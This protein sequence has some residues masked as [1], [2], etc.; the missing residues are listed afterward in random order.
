MAES[1]PTVTATP[2]PITPPVA[3]PPFVYNTVE[4]TRK[5]AEVEAFY[6][7]YHGRAGFNPHF[8]LNKEYLPLKAAH[9]SPDEAKTEELFKKIMTLKCDEAN[10][11]V[12]GGSY[13]GKRT[14]VQPAIAGLSEPA[15]RS[16][17]VKQHA[18]N[19]LPPV[20]FNPVVG[21]NKPTA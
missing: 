3:K 20:T 19:S 16:H 15:L 9:L 2:T 18:P 10:A 7:K 12:K 13:Y 4:A 21:L 17:E 5:L 14:Q 11:V 6:V 1:N 8:F